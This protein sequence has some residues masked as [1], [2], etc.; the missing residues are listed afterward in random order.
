ITVLVYDQSLKD[1]I[2]IAIEASDRVTAVSSALAAETYELI[3]PEKKIETIYN[4]ID[5]RV[6]LKKNTAVIKDKHGILPDEKD[7]IHLYNYRKV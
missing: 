1:L 3:K 4:Y 5:E 7:V 6:Y 2:R